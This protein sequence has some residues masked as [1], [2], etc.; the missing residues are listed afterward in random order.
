M[1][2]GLTG[3]AHARLPSVSVRLVDASGVGLPTFSHRG[4]TYIA[5]ETGARYGIELRNHHATRVEVVVTVDGRDVVSGS[6]GDYTTQRGY[7]LGPYERVIVDGYRQSLQQVATFRFGSVASSYSARR[8]TPQH[9]GVVG[10]AV[11]RERP[12][13]AARWR[14]PRIA[15]PEAS[16]RTHHAQERPTQEKASPSRRQLHEGQS[17]SSEAYDNAASPYRNVPDATDDADEP[18][19]LGTQYGESR[20][21]YVHEVPFS[22]ARR[23]RPDRLLTFY[24]D[25]LSALRARGVPVD[26]PR[27]YS[28]PSQ[29][30]PWPRIT[31][32][33]P[34][35]P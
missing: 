31:R 24:Y 35:P 21:S 28:L 32:F 17:A 4:N 11:F 29:R 12:E 10:V 6:L 16:T 5:G 26:P 34:P 13:K 23:T 25:S 18:Q 19:H 20:S 33:A 27:R 8:G 3:T 14:R 1:L 7:V 22:R 9:V 30:N 15:Q 2:I